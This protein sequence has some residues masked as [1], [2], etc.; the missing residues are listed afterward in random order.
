VI[1]THASMKYFRKFVKHF[2][3]IVWKERGSQWNIL[4][5]KFCESKLKESRIVS[6]QK[7]T[8]VKRDANVQKD[9]DAQT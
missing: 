9:V 1:P 3:K 5:S 7:E 4:E 6:L 8:I 2:K